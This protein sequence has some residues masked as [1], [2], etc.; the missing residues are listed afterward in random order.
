VR[1]GVQFAATV[2]PAAAS[3]QTIVPN[4]RAITL[5]LDDT[6]WPSAPTLTRAEQRA[7]AW[8]TEHAPAVAARW[9]LEQLRELRFA[10][11]H[12]HP[13]LHHDFLRIRRMAMHVAFEQAGLCGTPAD[14]LIERV[15][16]VFMTARNEVDLY[17]EVRDSLVR[18][19]RRFSLASLTNGNADVT[20]IGLG[21]HFKATISA[22]AHGV[23]KPDPALFH[24]ACRELGC[25]PGEVL[26]VGDDIELDVR[27]ARAAGLHVIWMNRSDA[28][29]RGD[30]VPPV[31]RD[32]T[33]LER[34]LEA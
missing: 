23:S 6:L 15:L 20:R 16:E 7:Y 28:E 9:P 22:H 29:W 1:A 12:Q 26:H 10:I 27:G 21:Q 33:G 4:I 31:V 13:E 11:F 3:I 24:I 34:W 8:L 17:P 30:D 2:N 32:L 18:L 14:E 5:D 25:A 19:S